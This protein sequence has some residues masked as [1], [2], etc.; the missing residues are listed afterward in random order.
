MLSAV[1]N[2]HLLDI[3]DF[4][5]QRSGKNIW[6]L[7]SVLRI[8]LPL[9]TLQILSFSFRP[10]TIKGQV[11]KVFPG[12]WESHSVMQHP[13]GLI[14]ITL[15]YASASQPL[16]LQMGTTTRSFCNTQ[17]T[18]KKAYFGSLSGGLSPSLWQEYMAEQTAHPIS[19]EV[20]RTR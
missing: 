9:L 15:L 18:K 11:S 7:G 4:G 16:I 10:E 20:R 6:Q 19:Q 8:W 2:P 17:L 14:F 1:G 12:G 3:S 13:A 5:C